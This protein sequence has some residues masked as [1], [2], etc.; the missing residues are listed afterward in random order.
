MERTVTL[1]KLL[2]INAGSTG[3]DSK[4]RTVHECRICRTEFDTADTTC[5]RCGSQIFRDKTTTPNATFNL[6]FVLVITGFAIAYN[7]LSGNYPKEG[8]A[9]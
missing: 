4:K 2:G 8:Q 9:G 1:K 5:P 7:I 6:L 3:I